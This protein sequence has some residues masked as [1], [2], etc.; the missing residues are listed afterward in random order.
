MCFHSFLNVKEGG[1]LKKWFVLLFFLIDLC[2]DCMKIGILD[3]GKGG[4]AVAKQ[5]QTEEDQLI[6]LL[7][8]GF[9]P[10]GEKS[11]EFLMTRSFYLATLLIEQGI[12]LLILACNTLSIIAYPFLKAN[13]PIPVIGIFDYF[14]PYLTENHILIGSK[15]TI[16]YAKNHYPVQVIDGTELIEG[17]E[18]GKRIDHLIQ[19]LKLTKGDVLLLG[20]THFLAIP[21]DAFP[22]PVLDQMSML[23]KDIEAYRKEKKDCSE[24]PF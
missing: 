6:V 23:K 11:K 12:E 8:Q 20:C 19:K 14:T 7:D 16:T 9:F 13:L 10:Y 18:K 15:A 21:K 17:I 4:L 22:I 1:F 24:Q 3:S 2:G 5:I